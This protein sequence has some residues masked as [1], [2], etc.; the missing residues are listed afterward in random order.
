MFLHTYK[1]HRLRFFLPKCLE[2]CERR[3]DYKDKGWA[4]R[5]VELLANAGCTD[6]RLDEV[7]VQGEIR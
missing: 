6:I 2:E 5:A 1:Q 4:M 7:E 3:Y